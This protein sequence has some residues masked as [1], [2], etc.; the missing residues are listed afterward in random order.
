[1]GDEKEQTLTRGAAESRVGDGGVLRRP[2]P[3]GEEGA[4]TEPLPPRQPLCR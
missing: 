4:V 1:M 2:H 3:W